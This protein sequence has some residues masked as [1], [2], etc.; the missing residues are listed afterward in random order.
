MF[1][2]LCLLLSGNYS[3]NS[4]LTSLLPHTSPVKAVSN[5]EKVINQR[6]NSAVYLLIGHKDF[7]TA[8]SYAVKMV[9]RMRT[10]SGFQNVRLEIDKTNLKQLQDFLFIYRYQLLTPEIRAILLNGRI[11]ELAE[12]AYMA[13]ASPLSLGSL[14]H[15]DLDPF[16]LVNS[17]L[18]Y[19]LN[20]G[21]LTNMSVGLRDGVLSTDYEGKSWVLISARTA[22][23]GFS[24][25]VEDSPISLIYSTA[26]QISS[27][28]PDLELV[29]SG[30]PFHSYES[31]RASRTEIS[32]LSTVSILFIILMI[33]IVFRSIKPLLAT[34]G[35]IIVGMVTGLAA[36]LLI[37]HD[38]HIFT[39]VFGTS[40]IGI[41][42]DYALHF[43][44]HW[45][46]LP[47]E[48]SVARIIRFILP[49]ISLGLLTT[50]ASYLA[51]VFTAF[52]LLQQ[53]ALFSIIG[54]M[55]SYLSVIFIFPKFK[56]AGEKTGR[57]SNKAGSFF[58]TAF[59]NLQ[60][61]PFLLK[62][63]FGILFLGITCA[64]L[65]QLQLNSDVRTLYQMSPAL[66]KSE[67]LMSSILK[68]GS[69]CVYVLVEGDNPEALRT[70]EEQLISD[71]SQ[72]RENGFI[73]SYLGSTFFIPSRGRQAENYELI[74]KYLKNAIP[75]QLES[76]GFGK[77]EIQSW[78]T[79][80]R[81]KKDQWV[82]LKILEDF[83]IGDLFAMLWL[84][85]AN[86]KYYS[87]VMLFNITNIEGVK[88]IVNS[89]SSRYFINRISEINSTLH[90]LSVLALIILCIS[91]V[92]IFGGLVFRYK[93]LRGF[94]I[95]II[96]CL[97]SCIVISFLN[98]AGLP[99]NV[100]S[101]MGL[102]LVP[103]M[104]TDYVIFFSEGKSHPRPTLLAITLSMLTTILSF[105]M[106]GFTSLAAVFG[107]TVALGVLL[108]FLLT[109]ILIGKK[110]SPPSD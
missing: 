61:L 24:V 44:A 108:S 98:L 106:L 92:L 48:K 80:Y 104:G 90:S 18:Q 97:A 2:F 56:R 65:S 22:G 82:D 77:A 69:S 64:G 1:I 93:W 54:L 40:L 85:Q 49:G 16:L 84:G 52:P 46:T 55:S 19:Y 100:F 63:F 5:V 79:D 13:V 67:T 75:A 96:P 38:V 87:M 30:A 34:V 17:S 15:L 47:G 8:R 41:S 58:Y 95:I 74:G 14:D 25:Q 23:S 36:T 42:L 31:S 107:L 102:I 39:I 28:E 32:F 94:K 45:A 27:V 10:H 33:L 68:H 26:E 21:I 20:S 105:G 35:A 11:Q 89:S 7:T 86:D 60:E 103:G 4:D 53:M 109:P 62:F 101:V 29:F 73:E 50:L 9:S 78:E 88:S 76:L 91:Y 81:E 70:K 6:F 57:I 83:P 51:F 72:A 59:K 99:F 110:E 37:F 71:L 43:F 12:N 3:V 66:K